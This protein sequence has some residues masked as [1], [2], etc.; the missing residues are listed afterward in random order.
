MGVGNPLTMQLKETLAV[1]GAEVLTGPTMI[2]GRSW[3][4]RRKIDL[5]NESKHDG[6]TSKCQA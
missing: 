6:V 5:A 1:C 3:E 4:R 2:S